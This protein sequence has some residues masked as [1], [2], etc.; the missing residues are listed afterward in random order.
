MEPT[1]GP[2]PDLLADPGRAAAR[3]ALVE[4]VDRALLRLLRL[5]VLEH[6]RGERRRVHPPVVHVGVPAGVVGGASARLELGEQRLDH[7][8]RVDVLEAMVRRTRAAGGTTLPSL[9]W[10]TRNGGSEPR[11]VD[12][13]WLAAARAA[14]AE[15]DL[16]LPMVVVTRRRWHDPSTGVAREWLSRL[17]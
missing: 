5:A 4:P 9:V 14:A 12:R 17:R 8:L 2:V 15:L 1:R 6:A 7:A 13:A 16:V 3:S 11:D 10:L